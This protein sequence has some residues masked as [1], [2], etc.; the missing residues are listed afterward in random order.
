MLQDRNVL[1]AAARVLS[2]RGPAGFTLERVAAEAGLSRVT[3]HRR[4]I[5]REELLRGLTERAIGDLREALW[6][7][8]TG[9]G[10]GADRLEAALAALCEVTERHLALLLGAGELRDRAFHDPGGLTRAEWASPFERL[11]RD[12]A[13]DGTLR[14][15]DDPAAAATVLFNL[16]G[17]TY[18]HLRSG[19]RWSAHRAREAVLDLAL[20]GVVS[21]SHPS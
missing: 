5:G 9:P 15:H 20:R 10:T 3:L 13:A 8:L 21:T 6:P 2:K 14:A 18:A 4:G 7:A 11:L 17:W 12:G 1:D 16:V 19:H